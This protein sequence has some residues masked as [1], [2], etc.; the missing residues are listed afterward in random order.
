MKRIFV[1]LVD[2]EPC[3]KSNLPLFSPNQPRKE[4]KKNKK[5]HNIFIC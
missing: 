1:K 3:L 5:D 4:K 2:S